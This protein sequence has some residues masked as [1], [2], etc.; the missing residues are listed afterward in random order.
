MML[1]YTALGFI[2]VFIKEKET[3]KC[4]ILVYAAVAVIA[5]C[6]AWKTRASVL[7]ADRMPGRI[8]QTKK[9]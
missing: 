4:L 9:K 6:R 5:G 3:R 1:T 8:A 7:R 2:F